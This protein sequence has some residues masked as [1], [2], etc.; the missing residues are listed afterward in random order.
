M[1]EFI[2]ITPRIVA[3]IRIKI[4]VKVKSF[5]G[6]LDFGIP[7]IDGGE[8]DVDGCQVFK[9]VRNVRHIRLVWFL[10]ELN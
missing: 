5:A 9:A 8:I 7:I 4:I 10:P 2:P 1:F 3:D 6:E